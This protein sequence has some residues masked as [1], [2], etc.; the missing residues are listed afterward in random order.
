MR[1]NWRERFP[2]RAGRVA[3]ARRPAELAPPTGEPE[4][5]VGL[6]EGLRRLR[7]TVL[8]PLATRLGGEERSLLRGPGLEPSEVREYQPGDDVRHIDWNVTA[9]AD[10]PF[11]RESLT[12]RAL[13]VWLLLDLS[14]SVDWGTA[15]CRKRDRAAE[16]A[17]V[18]GELL[19]GGGNRLGAILFAD[20]QL[21]VV[22]PGSGRAALLR[23]LGR[24][25]DEPRRAGH[26]PTDL[27]TV[28]AG[29][30]GIIRRRGLVLIVSDFLAPDGWQAPLAALAQRHEV[31]AVRLSDPRESA[32]PDIGIVTFEDPETGAQLTVDTGDRRL[33]ERFAA[34]AAD[35]SDRLR[36]ALAG[37]GVAE[38]ALDT[39]DELLPA[40]VSFLKARRLR[41]EGRGARGEGRGARAGG[42]PQ[43]G[44]F[45]G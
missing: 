43:P 34:A 19:A 22:P 14:A 3:R 17:A 16:F 30:G 6:E 24:L 38:L 29:A 23:L 40:L 13:D 36:A 18:A 44:T 35:Q 21:G 33:R 31:V 39:G 20:R 42:G 11:V 25:R 26:G 45:T 9:R 5:A 4:R 7:W 2:W 15:R 27:A 37:C 10:Q 8:R 32:L 28:L 1:H 41:H 12:E